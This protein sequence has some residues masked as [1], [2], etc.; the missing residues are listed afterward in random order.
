MIYPFSKSEPFSPKR[1]FGSW[2]FH[3]NLYLEP[4]FELERFELGI[5]FGLVF[6][7]DKNKCGV[8]FDSIRTKAYFGIKYNMWT[9]Y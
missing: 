3:S 2:I 1:L 6:R 4:C 5:K 8:D 7:R 9:L